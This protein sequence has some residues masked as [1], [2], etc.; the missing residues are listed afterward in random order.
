ML[1]RSNEKSKP[2]HDELPHLT[3]RDKRVAVLVQFRLGNSAS[4][5]CEILQQALG[6]QA[7]SLTTVYE[8]FAR[9]R[10]GTLSLDDDSREGRPKSAITDNYRCCETAP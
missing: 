10:C 1:R 7:P 9:F 4:K 6:A 3:D 8:W 5:C 2:N